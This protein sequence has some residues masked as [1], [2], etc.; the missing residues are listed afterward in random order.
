MI[1]G[2]SPLSPPNDGHPWVGGGQRLAA[3][4][5]VAPFGPGPQVGA[6]GAHGVETDAL[7]FQVGEEGGD[8]IGIRLNSFSKNYL[9]IFPGLNDFR[10]LSYPFGE[11][12]AS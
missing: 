2:A 10:G 8:R 9:A 5:P 12:L 3:G 11:I 7:V 6:V 1:C 4:S